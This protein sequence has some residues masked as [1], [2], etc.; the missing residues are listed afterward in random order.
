GQTGSAT[1]PHLHFICKYK[2]EYVDAMKK[3]K[4]D[5]L[6]VLPSSERAEFEQFK[7]PYDA[8]FAEI[9]AP[10]ALEEPQAEAAP[11]STDHGSDEGEDPGE[12]EPSAGGLPESDVMIK[13]TAAPAASGGQRGVDL[14]N[15]VNMSD[16][17]LLKAQPAV[18]D[19]E[20]E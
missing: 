10:P 18:D 19:G 11:A 1:G 3:L 17:D 16:D 5:A 12:D 20:V 14:S 8:M 6:A 13:P 15:A 4:F 9:K 7:Q 2:G